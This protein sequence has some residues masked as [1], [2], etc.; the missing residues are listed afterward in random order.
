MKN[1]KLK[2]KN[3]LAMMALKTK[4]LR[5]LTKGIKCLYAENY[6]ILLREIKEDPNKWRYTLF[7][8]WKCSSFQ[9]SQTDLK[10]QQTQSK[11]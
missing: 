8:T 10:I 6:K 1:Q 9:F 7:I 3:N 2:I 11:S 5:N 4:I